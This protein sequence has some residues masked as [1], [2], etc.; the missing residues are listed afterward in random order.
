MF[1][2]VGHTF[3]QRTLVNTLNLVKAQVLLKAG[4]VFLHVL[5]IS[6]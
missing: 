6:L 3:A 1:N 5:K 4:L 2:I